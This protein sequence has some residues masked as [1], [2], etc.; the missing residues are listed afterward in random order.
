MINTFIILLILGQRF[1]VIIS[2]FIIIRIFKIPE[3][4]KFLNND[5]SYFNTLL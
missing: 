3:S 4:S 5:V 2:N 1:K